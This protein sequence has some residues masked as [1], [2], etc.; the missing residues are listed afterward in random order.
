MTNIFYY[1]I[2][3][4]F[5]SAIQLHHVLD[6][7][8]MC[9]LCWRFIEW[10]QCCDYKFPM[11]ENFFG[12]VANSSL[13]RTGSAL[14]WTDFNGML[15]YMLVNTFKH[16][17]LSKKWLGSDHKEPTGEQS[18]HLN[19]F[20]GVTY[21]IS[22]VCEWMLCTH[23]LASVVWSCFLRTTYYILLG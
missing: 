19:F 22:R 7:Y 3:N 13:N 11:S 5:N 9:S 2:Y 12:T 6:M 10:L 21:S 16:S 20:R 4:T 14:N 17:C 8:I 23:T 18:A 15:P 1:K